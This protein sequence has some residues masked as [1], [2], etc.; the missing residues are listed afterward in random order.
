MNNSEKHER[1]HAIENDNEK[2]RDEHIHNQIQKSHQF[3]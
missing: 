1:I 2:N 3:A